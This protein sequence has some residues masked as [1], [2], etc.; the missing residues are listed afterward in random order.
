MYPDHMFKYVI[1]GDGGVGKSNLLLRF[2]DELFDPIHTTTLGV[3]FGYKDL[4][5][6]KYKVRLR[7]W[8]TCGQENF[9]SII[10]A[11]YRNALGALLVYDITCRKSFVHLE[12]WLSDLRQH[13]HPEMVIML[14]GNKSDLKAVR[15]VTTEEGE[16]FAKKNGLTF[17]ET[18]AK[19]NKHVEKAFVNTAHEIYKKLKL[20]VIEDDDVK[21]KKIGIIL[22]SR[23]GKEKKCC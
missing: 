13:G 14:I 9:R 11:Y 21:K 23:S 18:S 5:I 12:Q 1:I 16:A 8:D 19:A 22:R 15:D 4:Q 3:E 2:T 6:D 17:M 20:G 7:V 10:R